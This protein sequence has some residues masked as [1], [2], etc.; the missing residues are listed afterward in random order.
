MGFFV[1]FLFCH[2]V[3][4]LHLSIQVCC[5]PVSVPRAAPHLP[6]T[7]CW[8]E[9]PHKTRRTTLMQYDLVN[10]QLKP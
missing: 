1:S 10:T 6:L 9:S 2:P 3:L 4:L 7:S 8:I 5:V